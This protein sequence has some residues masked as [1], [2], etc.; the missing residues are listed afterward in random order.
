MPGTI[1]PIHT[2]KLQT[3]SLLSTY[4]LRFLVQPLRQNQPLTVVRTLRLHRLHAKSYGVPTCH[5]RHPPAETLDTSSRSS[6]K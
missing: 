2:I 3:Q 5:L 4:H 6:S 1:P